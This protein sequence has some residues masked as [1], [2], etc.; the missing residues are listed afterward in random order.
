MNV[1]AFPPVPP[2]LP[3]LP[4]SWAAPLCRGIF[5]R[6]GW[7]VAGE[8]PNVSKLVAIAAP[9]SSNWDVMWG[10]LVK[11]GL[12]LDVHFIGKRE[13]FFWPLGPILRGCGGVPIDRKRAQK[14]VAD[15]AA[16]FAA[17]EKFWLAIAPEGTRKKVKEWKSGFWRIAHAAQVPILPVY[18]HYPEKTIGFG[19]LIY[20]GDD[21]DADMARIREF[22]KPWM[23]KNRGT[24]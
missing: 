15:M 14:V 6:C 11:V 10:L 24:V 7:R 16:E 9:H 3:Q 5:A 4:P 21:A 22:Y 18:F 8:L 1:A 12:R 23:G 20:P 13:A 17:R 19:P 2:Q